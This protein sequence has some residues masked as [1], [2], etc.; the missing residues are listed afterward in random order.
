MGKKEKTYCG[1]WV[2]S[3]AMVY[4][5]GE[6]LTP[7]AGIK[8]IQYS[9]DGFGWGDRGAGAAQLAISILLDYLEN[10]QQTVELHQAFKW[11]FLV[12][13][14]ADKFEI[15]GSEIDEFLKQRNITPW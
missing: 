8:I 6:I 4:V 9:T 10:R 11:S 13:A 1:E 3:V 12:N 7:A 2:D 5:N 14:S 15:R